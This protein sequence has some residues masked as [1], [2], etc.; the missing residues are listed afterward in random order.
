MKIR[1][2]IRLVIMYSDRPAIKRG[3]QSYISAPPAVFFSFF[4]GKWKD[5]QLA[6]IHWAGKDILTNQYLPGNSSDA[7]G[8]KFGWK[9]VLHE[10]S[11]IAEFEWFFF[12][13]LFW[14]HVC[15]LNTHMLTKW[16]PA[17]GNGMHSQQ[18]QY[19]SECKR[20]LDSTGVKVPWL[21][22]SILMVGSIHKVW[23]LKL[24]VH[25]QM[26][27]GI[28]ASLFVAMETFSFLTFHMPCQTCPPSSDGHR[29]HNLMKHV[30]KW[31][32]N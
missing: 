1:E 17:S 19:L 9:Q 11:C 18:R 27:W 28:K 21:S 20:T 26:P 13:F 29:L 23:R 15:I 12:F 24:S 3:R 8:V 10:T 14:A 7:P 2:P 6:Q 5:Q 32:V 4:P 22:T 25:H 31:G 16:L 30:S